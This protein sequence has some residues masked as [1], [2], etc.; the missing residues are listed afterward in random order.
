MRRGPFVRR[1]ASRHTAPA[2]TVA[3]KDYPHFKAAVEYAKQYTTLG[4][5]AFGATP[6]RFLMPRYKPARDSQVHNVDDGLKKLEEAI[7]GALPS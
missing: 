1:L 5:N 6:S 3:E 7:K 4:E 2:H